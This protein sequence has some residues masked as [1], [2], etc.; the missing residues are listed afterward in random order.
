M[1]C[2]EPVLCA[3]TGQNIGV[4]I[5]IIIIRSQIRSYD[6]EDYQQDD[7]NQTQNSGFSLH[8]FFDEGFG[9]TGLVCLDVFINVI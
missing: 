1:V 7:D 9:F 8:E 5:F 4:I 6:C 2:S 3:W